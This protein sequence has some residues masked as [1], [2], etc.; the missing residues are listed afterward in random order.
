MP[1]C[2][3]KLGESA[4]AEWLAAEPADFK[5]AILTAVERAVKP[6]RETPP[7]L[8]ATPRSPGVAYSQSLLAAY[9]TGLSAPGRPLVSGLLARMERSA[10]PG[11]PAN[12]D[13]LGLSGVWPG[14]V[15]EIYLLRGGHG[16]SRRAIA[17]G[18]Q[19]FPYNQGLERRNPGGQD[20]C[21]STHL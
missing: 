8:P 6:E 3:L 5:E 9:P 21:R 17:R 14:D 2:S 10:R 19:P 16:K 4:D 1:P 20:V 11:L 13:W 15:A 7:Y 12:K 18:T